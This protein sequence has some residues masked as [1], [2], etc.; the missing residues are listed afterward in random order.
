MGLIGCFAAPHPPIIIPEV[1][2]AELDKVK[3]TVSSMQKLRSRA[4]ALSPDTVVLLSP[5]APLMKQKM[6]VSL[7]SAYEGDLGYFNAPDV[8]VDAEGDEGLAREILERVQQA[9]LP[10]GLIASTGETL[11]LDHGSMVP[12]AYVMGDLGPS[13]RLVLLS[14]S[15]Q[16]LQEHAEFGAAV[17]EAL[18]DAEQ[19][20]LYVAS[21]DLSHRLIPGAPAGF[22]PRGAEFDRQV[23]ESFS[24]GDWRALLSIDP[25]L[26]QAAGE[27]G[28]RSLAVLSGVVAASQAAGMHTQN[29]LYS[30]EGPFGVG[31]LVGEVEFTENAG[32]S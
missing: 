26:A 13:C 11:D 15:L 18:I 14:F 28:Y 30:Y 16:G 17:G 7:A 29:R 27:C 19:R 23:A 1:G 2:G 31:Y 21:S 3:S 22:D 24:S 10:V 9:G 32:G 20:I 8:L 5:H 6:G 25:E 12:L 4:A